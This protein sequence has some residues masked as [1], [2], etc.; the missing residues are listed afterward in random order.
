MITFIY[1]ITDQVSHPYRTTGKII[2][3]G[4]FIC[5]KCF[6]DRLINPAGSVVTKLA[7]NPMTTI[8]S[9]RLTNRY[10]NDDLTEASVGPYA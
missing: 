7:V 9:P 5:C 4:E 8:Y 3:P 2:T 10:R 1:T 6:T